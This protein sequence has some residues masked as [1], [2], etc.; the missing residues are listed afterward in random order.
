MVILVEIALRTSRLSKHL[1][2]ITA[3]NATDLSV[4]TPKLIYDTKKDRITVMKRKEVGIFFKATV[5][6]RHSLSYLKY[7]S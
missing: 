6:P 4:Y 5:Y 3:K 7:L 2:G 1:S